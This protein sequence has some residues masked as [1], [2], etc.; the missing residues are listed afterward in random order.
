LGSGLFFTSS[1]LSEFVNCRHAARGTEAGRVNAT[2]VGPRFSIVM[3]SYNQGP[4]IERSLLSVINQDYPNVELI[5]MDGGSS[6][7]TQAV[8]KKYAADIALWRSERD[9]GQSDALNKG[10]KHV[11]GQICG[12]LNSD[13]IYCPGAFEFVA[14]IFRNRPEVQVVYGDWYTLDLGDRISAH[15]FGLPYSRG[16]LITEGVFCNA[17]AMFWRREL[18]E[19][20]G[21]FDV[22]L[23]YTMDYDLILRL[24]RLT[25][26]KGFYRTLR[27]LGCFRVYPGQKTGAASAVDTVA[28]EHRLI[29]QRENTAWKYRVTGRAVRLYYRGKRVRDYFRRGGSAYVMW[30]LGVARNPVEGM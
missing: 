20:F 15:Y 19:R 5:V 28:S 4:L 7:G 23:H 17:Q 22:R 3:P 9:G 27:P 29:A 21:E 24:T 30:K 1:E 2:T 26:R 8:L 13:D 12:W 18:H 10:F 25:G 16:Q 6:D 14:G 11:T